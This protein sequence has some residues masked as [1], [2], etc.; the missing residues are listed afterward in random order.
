MGGIV[1]GSGDEFVVAVADSRR[2]V[3]YRVAPEADE[4][5]AIMGVLEVS[6]TELTPGKWHKRCTR[7]ALRS[8]TGWWNPGWTSSATGLLPQR[9]RTPAGFFGMRICWPAT[10]VGQRRLP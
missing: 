4:Y 5:I 3:A 9:A 6:V 7:P 1:R 8:R 2:A 10:G